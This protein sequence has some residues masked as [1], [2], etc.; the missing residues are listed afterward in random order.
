MNNKQNELSRVYANPLCESVG[1][2]A[3]ARAVA[4]QLA[5][6]PDIGLSGLRRVMLTEPPQRRLCLRKWRVGHLRWCNRYVR[7]ATVC[8]GIAQWGRSNE[9]PT[10]AST[11]MCLR[12]SSTEKQQTNDHDKLSYGKE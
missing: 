1:I 3:R 9:K 8:K 11:W 5:L 4:G 7:S 10:A 6:T 12:M 2:A